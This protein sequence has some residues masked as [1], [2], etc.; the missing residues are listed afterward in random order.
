MIKEKA[1]VL[2]SAV[3]E[4]ATNG[5]IAVYL[6]LDPRVNMLLVMSD[7]F[8]WLDRKKTECFR[9]PSCNHFI[10]PVEKSKSFKGLKIHDLCRPRD[11]S[12]PVKMEAP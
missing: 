4:L 6:T 10:L 9:C 11:L 1:F 12:E 7:G 5:K 2:R 8:E 3:P